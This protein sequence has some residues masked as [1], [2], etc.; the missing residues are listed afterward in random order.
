MTN[1]HV[2]KCIIGKGLFLAFLT[3]G[4]IFFWKLLNGGIFLINSHLW[5][6]HKSRYNFVNNSRKYG[7]EVVLPLDI[8]VQSLQVAKQNMLTFDEYQKSLLDELDEIN[9]NLIATLNNILLNKRKIEK[10]CN[11]H[12]KLSILP[13]GVKYLEV[14]IWSLNWEEPFVV[15]QVLPNEVYT[16]INQGGNELDRSI[17]AKYLEIFHPSIWEVEQNQ[18]SKMV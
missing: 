12:G 7:L 6:S 4:D 1:K 9:E 8:I 14:D 18:R 13:M 15:S 2:H 3:F 11:K 16:L 5:V 17:N 10:A